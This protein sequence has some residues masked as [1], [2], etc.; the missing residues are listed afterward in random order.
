MIVN[1]EALEPTNMWAVG[2]MLGA[3]TNVPSAMWTKAPSRT[4]EY[5][6]E[7]Q[8][9][10]RTSCA[11]FSP[12]TSSSSVPDVMLTLLRAPNVRH[13]RRRKGR[14]AAFGT[15]ARWECEGT[16]HLR[17][18]ATMRQDWWCLKSSISSQ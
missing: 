14:E 1:H 18:T 5:S 2:L 15:S 13:E 10:Q 3:S 16:S 11:C 9:L 17:A 8:L 7:Q 12:K 6:K 4:T